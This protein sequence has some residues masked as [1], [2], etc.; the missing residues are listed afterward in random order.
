MLT[1]GGGAVTHKC[2]LYIRL[3]GMRRGGN[4]AQGVNEVVAMLQGG[5]VR[6]ADDTRPGLSSS[7]SFL[8]GRYSLSPAWI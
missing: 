5:A 3:G 2:L 8:G 4:V 7:W 6:H 1:G